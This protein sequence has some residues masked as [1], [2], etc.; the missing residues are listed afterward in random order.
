MAI[1]LLQIS[2]RVKVGRELGA[3]IAVELRP[4]ATIYTIA[5]TERL[6]QKF[7]SAPTDSKALLT[8]G[9]SQISQF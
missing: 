9:A 7:I 8:P 4:R 1:Q 5:F 2:D 3:V 6:P